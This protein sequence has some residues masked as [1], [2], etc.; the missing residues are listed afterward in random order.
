M[1]VKGGW[2]L[3]HHRSRSL[4]P[5]LLL[6][7]FYECFAQHAGGESG[8][9]DYL[10]ENEADTFVAFKHGTSFD[11]SYKPPTDVLSIEDTKARDGIA[12]YGYMARA[13]NMKDE[14]VTPKGY[15]LVLPGN[16]MTAQT[17]IP[18]LRTF[19][20]HGYDT[21]V[22]DYRG[23]GRSQGRTAVR[24]L[25]D[26][27]NSIVNHLS[28]LPYKTRNVYAV[29]AG[30]AIAVNGFDKNSQID[31]IIFDG[32]PASISL[33]VKSKLAKLLNKTRDMTCPAELDPI[34]RSLPPGR[35]YLLIVAGKDRILQR[36]Q[37]ELQQQ[38]LVERARA[39]GVCIVEQPNFG[40]PFQDE[41]TARRA[42]IAAGFYT[43]PG[44]P[45]FPAY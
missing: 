24:A 15:I 9:E 17:L 38:R 14:F 42:E 10:C 36:T 41:F 2:I 27:A 1:P 7:S 32:L 21:Y 6:I 45:T 12:L 26:D 20:R 11:P 35:I 18:Q 33:H 23:Y 3:S 39:T 25:I 8:L 4:L 31:R 19:S 16:Q 37:H 13:R 34:N 29:S 22:Y 28:K 44:C 43:A 5:I 40:H 30:A